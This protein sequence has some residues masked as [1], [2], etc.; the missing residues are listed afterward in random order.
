MKK[1][2]TLPLVVINKLNFD[3]VLMKSI[4]NNS[5]YDEGTGDYIQDWEVGNNG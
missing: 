2:Y 3:D 5:Y 1:L 4:I